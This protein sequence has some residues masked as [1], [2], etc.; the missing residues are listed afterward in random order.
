MTHRL[1]HLTAILALSCLGPVVSV[2]AEENW[3]SGWRGPNRDGWVSYVDPPQQWPEKLSPRWTVPVGTGYGSPLVAGERV[4]QHARVGADEV[5]WCLDLPS[6]ATEWRQTEPVPFKM[7]GGGESHGKGPKSSPALSD[8]RLFTLSINGALTAWNAD[9]GEKL[10]RRDYNDR[11]KPGHPYWGVSTSPLVDEDRVIVHFGNDEVGLLVALDVENGQELWT[12]G[13]DGLRTRRPS[14]LRLRGVRQ[15]IEW[16]HR[17]LVGVDSA[18]GRQLWEYPFPHVGTD[19]NMPTPAFHQGMVLLGGENRGI[20]GLEPSLD[21]GQW[22]VRKR[23]DQ[24]QVALDMS[25][26]VVN[27]DLLFGF[28]HYDKGRIFCLD[29]KPAKFNGRGRGEREAT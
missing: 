9:S 12:L 25:S 2:W 17:A 27:G 21:G 11:F 22:S 28:S 18:T 14:W 10:W 29:R 19:Q 16:N 5:V 1:F 13:N 6:G 24:S 3:W 26:A 15:I 8:G 20:H 4:Y 7:G 23:W